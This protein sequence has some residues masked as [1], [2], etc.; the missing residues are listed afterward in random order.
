MRGHVWHRLKLYS[1]QGH[2][3][4]L[5]TQHIEAQTHSRISS[6]NGNE[7]RSA[8]DSAPPSQGAQAPECLIDSAFKKA[9]F[10]FPR[11]LH[12]LKAGEF[13]AVFKQNAYR[14][15]SRELLLLARP[16][17]LAYPRLGLVV[18]KR[19]VRLSVRRNRL[20]R[21]LRETFRHHQQALGSHDIVALVRAPFQDIPREQLYALTEQQWLKLIKHLAPPLEPNC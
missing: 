21:V 3:K 13:D 9:E 19:Q 11:H 1:G 17:D 12:L 14:A 7:K 16:N 2:E 4:N 5:P 15:S 8:S 18:A 20:K 6:Q 10:G